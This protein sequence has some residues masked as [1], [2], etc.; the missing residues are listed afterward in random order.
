ML[1]YSSSDSFARVRESAFWLRAMEQALKQYGVSL[2]SSSQL[3]P[4]ITLPVGQ[5]Q[6]VDQAL[7]SHGWSEALKVSEDPHF[8]LRMHRVFVPTPF[9]TLALAAAASEHIEAALSLLTRFFSLFSIQLK[10]MSEPDD[11]G[12]ALTLRPIGSPHQQHVEAVI[13]YLARYFNRL[14]LDDLGLVRK[15]QL[16]RADEDPEGQRRLFS[17]NTVEFGDDYRLVLDRRLMHKPLATSSPFILPRLIE[18]LEAMQAVLPSHALSEQVKR[19]I[20]LLLGSGDIS[21]ERVAAPL[22]IS[23]RHLRR[24]LSQE[25]TSYEQLADDVRREAALRMISDG[26]LSLTSIAYELGFLDPS[27]FTRAF[28]RWTSMSPT[29]YRR[30]LNRS[31]ENP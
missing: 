25:G 4:W 2:G 26:Q 30:E 12:I 16:V 11:E 6:F 3:A 5:P 9:A 24:K 7:C 19:R 8:A 18:T 22:N 10:L 13:G 20:H 21:A 28:R 15:L 17:R 31:E 29:A 23:P 1:E 14:D 27:S